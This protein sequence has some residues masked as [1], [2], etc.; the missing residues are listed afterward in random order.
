V[1]QD[2]VESMHVAT[3]NELTANENKLDNLI[4]LLTVAVGSDGITQL[5]ETG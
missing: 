5:N 2:F 1:L 4:E 3:R